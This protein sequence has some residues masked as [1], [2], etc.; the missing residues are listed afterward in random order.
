M[1]KARVEASSFLG[2]TIYDLEFRVQ[3]SQFRVHSLGFRVQGSGFRVQGSGFVNKSLQCRVQGDEHGGSRLGP[4]VQPPTA[5]SLNICD[6]TCS[7]SQ[8]CSWFHVTSPWSGIHVGDT[9]ENLSPL[10]T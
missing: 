5:D 2:F 1:L 10:S 4:R 7:S 8:S 9:S 6:W 3:G